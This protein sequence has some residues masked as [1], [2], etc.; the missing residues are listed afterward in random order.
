VIWLDYY[1]TNYLLNLLIG[2][3]NDLWRYRVNDSTWTWMSGS[4]TI[5]QI[6]VYGEK[7]N[8]SMNSVPGARQNAVGW[9]DRLNQELWLFGGSGCINSTSGGGA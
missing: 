4:N 2:L 1:S 6:G 5:Q 9:F 8:A 7:G 3:L